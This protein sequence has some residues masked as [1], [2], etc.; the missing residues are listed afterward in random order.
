MGTDDA[1]RENL[2][3]KV[4]SLNLWGLEGFLGKFLK[5]KCEYTYLVCVPVRMV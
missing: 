1:A 5:Q 3:Q 2:G 4:E